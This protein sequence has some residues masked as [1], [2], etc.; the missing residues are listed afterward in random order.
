MQVITCLKLDINN[1]SIIHFTTTFD[2]F[3]SNKNINLGI[4]NLSTKF[5]L[6][7]ESQYYL[8]KM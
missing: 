3:K 8:L 5:N 6:N 4:F 2:N 7:D 1:S